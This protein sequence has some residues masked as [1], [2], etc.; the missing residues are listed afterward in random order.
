MED[1]FLWRVI[2]T[3]SLTRKVRQL[4]RSWKRVG[5]EARGPEVFVRFSNFKVKT[6]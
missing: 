4:K 3:S 1:N 2:L 5:A 6:L